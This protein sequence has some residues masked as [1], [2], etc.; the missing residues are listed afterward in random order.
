MS[1]SPATVTATSSP[2][3]WRR[4]G[5]LLTALSAFQLMVVLDAS[6]VNIALPRVQAD[7]VFSATGLS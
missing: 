6:V 4:P 7:L 3:R 1:A 5:L 2:Q